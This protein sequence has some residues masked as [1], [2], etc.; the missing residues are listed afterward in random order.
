MKFHSHV[1]SVVVKPVDALIFDERATT[2]E[3]D[4]EGA[5]LFLTVQQH[6]DP[7]KPGAIRFDMEEWPAI[8]AAIE[9]LIMV[10]KNPHMS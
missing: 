7:D 10:I 9:Q 3:L 5:G 6:S 8:K 1:L 2:V 4:D